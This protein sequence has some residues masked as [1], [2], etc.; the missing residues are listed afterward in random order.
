MCHVP[1]LAVSAWN[2]FVT[3]YLSPCTVYTGLGLALRH[4]FPTSG[5]VVRV[6][7]SA[8]D[9]EKM[10]GEH[11]VGRGDGASTYLLGAGQSVGNSC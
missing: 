8:I 11:S 10:D 3:P 2:L 1:F 9:V 5:T 6:D 7:G 4:G